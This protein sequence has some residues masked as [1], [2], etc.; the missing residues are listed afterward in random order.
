ME[1][2]RSDFKPKR[3]IDDIKLSGNES[4]Y[5][6]KRTDF[7][8][9]LERIENEQQDKDYKNY[10][11]KQSYNVKKLMAEVRE[12]QERQRS[13]EIQKAGIASPEA[14]SSSVSP[15][16]GGDDSHLEKS[17]M[18]PNKAQEG[19]G[20]KFYSFDNVDAFPTDI[21]DIQAMVEELGPYGLAPPQAERLKSVMAIGTFEHS[22]L[23]KNY[24]YLDETLDVDY[25]KDLSTYSRKVLRNSK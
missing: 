11:A 15:V 5:F 9:G 6:N 4:R 14:R 16:K 8:K 1:E 17:P 10:F 18:T 22:V 23:K 12:E 7:L 25:Y 3:T 20:K 13:V 24:F 2:P 19:K 21:L